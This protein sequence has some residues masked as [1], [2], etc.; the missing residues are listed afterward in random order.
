MSA[1]KKIIDYIHDNP[2]VAGMVSVPWEYEWSSSAW[3]HG[4]GG[5][6]EPDRAK[7]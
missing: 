7:Y 6:F 3:Y 1:C 5:D 4:R 2:V